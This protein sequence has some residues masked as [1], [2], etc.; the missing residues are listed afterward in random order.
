MNNIEFEKPHLLLVDGTKHKLLS[1]WTVTFRGEEYR[2][3]MEFITDGASIPFWL[4]PICGDPNKVPRVYAALMHDWLYSGGDPEAT[5]ADA[6]D[7]YRDMQ[8]ALGVPRWKAYVEWT[9]LR[10]F[11]RSHWSA[12]VKVA[13]AAVIL[14]ATG[15]CRTIDIVKN[16]AGWEVHYTN[17]GLKTDVSSIEAEK[18]AEG[19]I[20]VKV[21]GVATD[22]SAE[23][24]EIVAAGGT[25]VGNVA[26]KIIDGIKK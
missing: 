14:A 6:D 23:N 19:V 12:A 18:T 17:L 26:E 16:D 8:I 4:Q 11:G 1:D 25:A 24:K 10:I 7:L 2:V 15:C 21:K 3:P 22:V 9:A 20:K 5:R 13:M